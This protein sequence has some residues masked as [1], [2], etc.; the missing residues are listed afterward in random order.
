MAGI[1]EVLERLV[2]DGEF[3]AALARDPAAALA[4][5]Y[6]TREDAELL[7]GRLDDG[8][9]AERAVEQ[10]SS[11]S[12]MLSL[13]SAVADL[14]V[15]AVPGEP[16]EAGVREPD[17]LEPTGDAPGESGGQAAGHG[18]GPGQGQGAGPGQGQGG[19]AGQGHG[20]GAGQGQGHGGGAGQGQGG[21]ED[22]STT[23]EDPLSW[24]WGERNVDL[25]VVGEPVAGPAADDI[26]LSP[27]DP[28][29]DVVDEVLGLGE[30]APD[31]GAPGE[32][33][34]DAPLSVPSLL[35]DASEFL[36][37]S[38]TPGET[39][40]DTPGDTSSIFTDPTSRHASEQL[41]TDDD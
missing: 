27:P 14:G 29:D 36:F 6:L 21:G 26:T 28:F 41:G 8:G 10:R 24:S 25:G 19:G 4:G 34:G 5:Y 17:L 31:E 35:D 1:D 23:D 39:P 7:A 40:E 13:L 30:G 15:E 3:R 20:G 22:P 16:L 38:D 2:T 11:K 18:A 32:P 9:G 12:A 37:G 33:A